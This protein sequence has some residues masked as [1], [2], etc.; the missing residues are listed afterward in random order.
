VEATVAL[1]QVKAPVPQAAQ[2]VVPKNPAA[3]QATEQATVVLVHKVQTPLD[4]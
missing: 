1:E 2:L 4:N 3:K